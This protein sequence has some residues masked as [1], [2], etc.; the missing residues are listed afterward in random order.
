MVITATTNYSLD[1]LKVFQQ[2]A[3]RHVNPKYYAALRIFYL[4]A[5]AAAM[6]IGVYFLFAVIGGDHDLVSIALVGLGIYMGAQ[7]LNMGI[8]YYDYFAKRAMASIP[9]SGLRNFYSFEK[10]QIVLSNQARSGSYSYTQ[11]GYIYETK[12]YFLFYINVKNGYVLEKAG[13]ENATSD[14]LRELLNSKCT[15]PV[16]QLTD[17]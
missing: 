7:L 6:G 1:G 8:Q 12:N 4:L 17:I 15:Y 3:A 11:F 2:V 13:I 10:D 14:Q 9:G 16:I 5:G